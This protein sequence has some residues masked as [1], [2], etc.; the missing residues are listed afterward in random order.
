MTSGSAIMEA[1]EDDEQHWSRSEWSASTCSA[2][3]QS[4]RNALTCWTHIALAVVF[5]QLPFLVASSTLST[6]PS[7]SSSLSTFPTL[8]SSPSSTNHPF[9]IN[10]STLPSTSLLTSLNSA[11]ILNSNDI[12]VIDSP[13]LTLSQ[14]RITSS[15]D[16]SNSSEIPERQTE[17][18]E[19]LYTPDP[20]YVYFR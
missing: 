16:Y 7:N 8:L 17:N 15:E 13:N 18:A 12:L 1:E 4:A 9:D 19:I 14:P 11:S 2:G 6:T 3:H 20:E 10:F 5:A